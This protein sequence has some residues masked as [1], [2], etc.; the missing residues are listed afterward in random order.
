MLSLALMRPTARRRNLACSTFLVVFLAGA[1]YGQAP[2]SATW[3]ITYAASS[4]SQISV[5]P[6]RSYAVGVFAGAPCAAALD[7]NGN[8]TQQHCLK[9]ALTDTT[10]VAAAANGGWYLSTFYANG[11]LPPSYGVGVVKLGPAGDVQWSR[12]FLAE[13]RIIVVTAKGTPDGGLILAGNRGERDSIDA[14]LGEQAVVLKVGPNGALDWYKVFDITGNE[15]LTSV[16]IMRDGY[17]ASGQ[18]GVGGWLVRLDWKGSVRWR[19]FLGRILGGCAELPNGDIFAAGSTGM[20]YRIVRLAAAD[21]H[22]LWQKGSYAGHEVRPVNVSF[23]GDGSVLVVARQ[24][25]S[26]PTYVHGLQL[27]AF[28]MWGE[29]SWQRSF[30]LG[31]KRLDAVAVTPDGG[32]IVSTAGGGVRIG[33][34]KLDATGHGSTCI[35]PGALPTSLRFVD[36]PVV[37]EKVSVELKRGGDSAQAERVEFSTS[38][39]MAKLDCEQIPRV[40]ATPTPE[41]LIPPQQNVLDVRAQSQRDLVELVTRVTSAFAQERFDELDQMAAEFRLKRP[42]ID[43]TL[44][45][46]YFY[47]SLSSANALYG[48]EDAHLALAEAWLQKKPRSPAAVVTAAA[49]Y[50]EWAFRARGYGFSASVTDEAWKK[51]DRLTRRARQIIEQSSSFASVDPHYHV[52]RVALA[53]V[54]CANVKEIAYDPKAAAMQYQRFFDSAAHFLQ[55]K[56]CGSEEEYLK[57]AEF[58]AGQTRDR[59]GDGLYAVLAQRV[60]DAED[61]PDEAVLSKYGFQWSRIRQGF[62]DLIARFPLNVRNVH[63]LAQLAR[64]LGD[65]PTAR[66]MFEKPESLWLSDVEDIWDSRAAYDEARK[67]ALTDSFVTSSPPGAAQAPGSSTSWATTAA[68]QWPTLF[69]LNKLE[70]KDGKVYDRFKS[71][72]VETPKGIV[73]VS[74]VTQLGTENTFQ[75]SSL[76]GLERNFKVTHFDPVPLQQLRAQMAKWT[77]TPPDKKQTVEATTVLTNQQL[78]G[79]HAVVLKLPPSKSAAPVHVLKPRSEPLEQGDVYYLVGCRSLGGR[80]VQTAFAGKVSSMDH[81]PGEF[82]TVTFAADDAIDW[83]DFIGSPVIDKNGFAVGVIT[84]PSSGFGREGPKKSEMTVE[85]TRAVLAAAGF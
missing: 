21:G 1:T 72:L 9:T 14:S 11:P 27:I 80:C 29:P 60:T 53:G 20:N 26:E 18:S 81:G 44:L 7:R 73:A 4:M 25:M 71:F 12:R 58:A 55:P 67:W 64:Q 85:E 5:R 6:D 59:F 15:S 46:E 34:H 49:T 33:V 23:R 13:D 50:R 62:Q 52:E 68:S 39:P 28:S 45:L 22:V 16:D 10:I 75:P 65:R 84:G 54:S 79:R 51:W 77:M 3:S 40:A 37:T 76:P 63:K 66:A 32:T 2:P 8:V 24:R 83:A 57:F 47:E 74:A 19:Q 31:Q 43:G 42:E 41:P 61:G 17:V 35:E 48:N 69:M 30:R 70:L 82:G 38:R 78:E 56:W 36:V